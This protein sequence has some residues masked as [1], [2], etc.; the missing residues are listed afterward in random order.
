MS[1][2]SHLAA[3]FAVTL[4]SHAQAPIERRP[5]T[6]SPDWDAFTSISANYL[7]SNITVTGSGR[8]T[9]CMLD[10]VTPEGLFC[11]SD[12]GP[13][14]FLPIPRPAPGLQFT[15]QCITTIRHADKPDTTLLG[16]G[17]G[18]AILLR[19]LAGLSL[20]ALGAM[21]IG[22]NPE[23]YQDTVDY[24]RSSYRLSGT[25]LELLEQSAH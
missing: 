17:I 13:A 4:A 10:Q 24:L 11:H 8:A 5:P 3:L 23:P 2:L 18:F 16:I 20:P 6:T 1:R 25:T 9:R 15:R 14:L 19:V 12:F 22:D 21:A 7:G